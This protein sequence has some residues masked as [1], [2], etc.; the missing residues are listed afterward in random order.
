MDNL[1]KDVLAAEKA[2][3]SYGQ[4]KAFHPHTDPDKMPLIRYPKRKPEGS[5]AICPVCGKQF[6]VTKDRAKYC[7]TDC[8]NRRS[9]KA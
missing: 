7:S 2:G 8:R 3:M 6:E 5:S 9:V 4:W 1:T